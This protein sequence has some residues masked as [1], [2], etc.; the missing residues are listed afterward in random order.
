MIFCP[1]YPVNPVFK[2]MLYEEITKTV[3]G[4]AYKVYNTLGFGFVERVYQ[5]ALII[6]LENAGLKVEQKKPISV[7][8]NGVVV[9]EFEADLVVE[10]CVIVELKSVEN[11]VK[12]FE[13]QTV[14]YLTATKID[15]G[16]L[17]NFGPK[18]VEVKRK[19]REPKCGQE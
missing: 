7:Y 17:M 15:V 10:G 12:A 14:N 19:F 8:Y 3:I 4:C 5:N 1:V 11:L 6:E 18:R 2:T 16:L 9:G 13:V